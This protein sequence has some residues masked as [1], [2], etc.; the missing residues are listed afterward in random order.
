MAVGHG[1]EGRAVRPRKR[2]GAQ[3]R[4]GGGD[5]AQAELEQL[6]AALEAARDGDFNVR[7]PPTGK[8]IGADL[9]RRITGRGDRAMRLR[10]V[11]NHGAGVE[12]GD[13]LFELRPVWMA[14]PETVAQ[15]FPRQAIFDLKTGGD[16]VS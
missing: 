9:R 14:S 8:G 6:L 11:I 13:P 7:L 5:V 1:S 12:G 2:A 15:L 16:A 10:Q 3:A 4:N